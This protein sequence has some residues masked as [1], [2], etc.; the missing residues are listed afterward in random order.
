[1]R[2]MK[3]KRPEKRNTKAGQST[4]VAELVS[5][6][7]G[8]IVGM[9]QREALTMVQNSAKLARESVQAFAKETAASFDKEVTRLANA[10]HAAAA[11]WNENTAR[12]ADLLNRAGSLIETLES[13][14]RR[15]AATREDLV[16]M[17]SDLKDER[18][19]VIQHLVA[20][21]KAFSDMNERL[22][23]V[24]FAALPNG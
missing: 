5:L 21:N 6:E 14:H 24:G 11:K 2:T 17:S 15:C 4:L 16:N 12:L 8:R 19:I 20:I 1:M 22:S 3:A 7:L 13:L 23:R 9:M 18:G 10:Q